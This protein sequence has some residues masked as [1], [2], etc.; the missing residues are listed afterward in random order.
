MPSRAQAD[1]SPKLSVRRRDNSMRPW[2]RCV[3]RRA[4]S[5]SWRISSSATPA[6]CC[7]E[8]KS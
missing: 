6:R 2:A 1:S 8:P 3:R 4:R 5:A 7:A